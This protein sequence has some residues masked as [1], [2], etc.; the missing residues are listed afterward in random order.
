MYFTMEINIELILANESDN[1]GESIYL[2]RNEKYGLWVAYGFSAYS[3]R[4]L[5]KSK[6]YDS[7][8]KYSHIVNMPLT[9]VD[10]SVIMGLYRSE[11]KLTRSDSYFKVNF[12]RE[13]TDNDYLRWETKLKEIQD[14]NLLEKRESSDKYIKDNMST[15]SRNLKRILD[16]SIS[17]VALII[18]S[19]LM[20]ICHIA[21]KLED[22]GSSIFKQER[23]GRFGKPFY[24]YKFRS[25]RLNAEDAGP[26]L[27]TSGG[28]GDTRLTKVGV[29]IRRHHLDELPQLWNVF[30]GDMAFVGPRPER[31]FFIDQILEY[32]KRYTY[33][34]QIRPGVT[35]WATLYNGYT[36]T[37][38]K[39][40]SRLQLDLYYLEH[41][42]LFKDFVI[43]VKTF[44]KIV[45]GK[46]F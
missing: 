16:M 3:L 10:D 35:S 41:R 46:V 42:T 17:L 18:F 28:K 4:L 44:F 14:T 7:I 39:M 23:I 38:E 45:F 20:L 22:G 12:L 1:N 40:L 6:G 32:D 21:I 31:K 9:M 26:Q 5:I 27:S 34:Y 8:R 37:I 2:Y 36:D 11:Y 15:F 43:L 30:C 33:L 29:F 13:Y 24:I 25:M 19:P